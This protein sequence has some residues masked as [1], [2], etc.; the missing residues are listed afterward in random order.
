MPGPA[1]P[2]ERLDPHSRRLRHVCAM[3]AEPPSAAQIRAARRAYYGA[4]SYVDDNLGRLTA[5]LSD[6]GLSGNTIVIFLGDHGE[7]LGERGLWYKMSFFEGAARVPLIVS[8]PGRFAPARVAA[9]V[10]LLDFTPTLVDLAGGD[11]RELAGAIDGRSL[12]P[13]LEGAGGHDE[14]IGEYLAEGAIAPIVMIRRGAYKFIH[15][16]ADP[17]QLYDVGGDPFER[18]N[19]ATR[20]EE[21]ERID[22]FRREA[23]RRWDLTALDAQVRASQRRRRVVDAALNT[24]EPRAWDFQPPRDASKQYVRNT[25]PLDA[26][27]ARA[28]FPRVTP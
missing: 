19:L 2:P 18:D 11:S 9:S 10:S 28:R 7:M 14:A 3:D 24:G 20:P 17:D 15:S 1:I 6:C 5:A 21:A 16:P 4:I 25:I 23:A 13:H 27:E 26:L 22:G 12:V 8:A